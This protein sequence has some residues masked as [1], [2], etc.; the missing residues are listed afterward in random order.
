MQ[1]EPKQLRYRLPELSSRFEN[2]VIGESLR[3]GGVS[4]EPYASLNL[5]WYSPDNKKNIEKN[6]SLLFADF[7]FSE[8][9]KAS[10]CLK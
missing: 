8:E 6:R 7:N 2:L 4:P 5:S 3:H 1:P 10:R 9:V